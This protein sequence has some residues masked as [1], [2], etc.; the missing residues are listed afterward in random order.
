MNEQ[1]ANILRI[2]LIVYFTG[3]ILAFILNAVYIWKNSKF[4]IDTDT[5]LCEI[6]LSDVINCFIGALFSYAGV[7]FILYDMYGNK[8]V[9]V[10]KYKRKTI[11]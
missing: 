11:K 6:R 3:F 1:D 4:N 7:F 5:Y 10:K 8:I 2:I 9:F